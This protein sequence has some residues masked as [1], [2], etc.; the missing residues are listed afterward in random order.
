MTT[1]APTCRRCHTPIRPGIATGQT[2][3]GGVPDFPGDTHATTLSAGGPGKVISVMKCPE[4]GW[5]VTAPKEE[6]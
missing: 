3:T 5:S 1:F 4:C 2:F 6:T